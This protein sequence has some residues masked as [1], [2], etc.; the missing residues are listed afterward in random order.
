MY[1]LTRLL[2]VAITLSR[3]TE[4]GCPCQLRRRYRCYSERLL[5]SQQRSSVCSDCPFPGAATSAFFLSFLFFLNFKVSRGVTIVEINFQIVGPFVHLRVCCSLLL[6]LLLTRLIIFGKRRRGSEA[7]PK[8][9][10]VISFS[11]LSSSSLFITSQIYLCRP[12]RRL[13]VIN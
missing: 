2:P 11:A 7:G 13:L 6:L 12:L 9:K 1:V 8:K 3:E 10:S 4:T 5:A